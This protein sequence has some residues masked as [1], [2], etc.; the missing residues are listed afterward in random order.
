MALVRTGSVGLI[1]SSAQSGQQSVTVPADAEI[2]VIGA[3]GY[4]AA[5][6]DMFDGGAADDAN[7]S[8]VTLGGTNMKIGRAQDEIISQMVGIYYL[9]SPSTGSVTLAWDWGVAPDEGVGIYY[10][11]YK[12]LNTGSPIR[13]RA[14]AETHD[15]T[16]VSTGSMSAESGDLA[17]AVSCSYG[18]TLSWTNATEVREDLYN[19]D[20]GGFAEA[21]PSA[22]VNITVT[23]SAGSGNFN[24]IV[25][26]VLQAA[27]GGGEEA[28][29]TFYMRH[30]IEWGSVGLA[31]AAG[32]QG[33][34][35]I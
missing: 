2:A 14:N 25:G 10:A 28:E 19:S 32:L 30:R 9:V 3:F 31:N 34:I 4:D 29:T 7:T 16:S 20:T 13:S 35:E 8:K 15:S 5:T 27:A 22:S 24:S 18:G 33:V 17:I 1:T 23:Q 6:A 21:S 26:I 12:G 11:F